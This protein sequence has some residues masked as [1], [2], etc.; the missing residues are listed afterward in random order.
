V[1]AQWPLQLADCRVFDH[2][3]LRDDAD[4]VLDD[5]GGHFIEVTR[6][7]PASRPREL[8]RAVGLDLLD[9]GAADII[10]RTQPKP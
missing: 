7:G 8:G 1:G 9:K 10:A 6:S 2:F 4:S 5:A 3:G